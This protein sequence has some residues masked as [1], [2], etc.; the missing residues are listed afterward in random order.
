[1]KIILDIG[2]HGLGPCMAIILFAHTIHTSSIKGLRFLQKEEATQISYL[3]QIEG[4]DTSPLC[5]EGYQNLHERVQSK[6]LI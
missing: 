2:C 4:E 5:I 6:N 1:M 3:H